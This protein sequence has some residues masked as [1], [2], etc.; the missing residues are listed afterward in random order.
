VL[1]VSW[2]DESKGL[3]LPEVAAYMENEKKQNYEPFEIPV[4]IMIPFRFCK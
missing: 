3:F 4:C 1:D 2:S